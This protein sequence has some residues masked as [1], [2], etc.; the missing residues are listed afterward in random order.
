MRRMRLM[1]RNFGLA[2]TRGAARALAEPFIP[3]GRVDEATVER[4]TAF[5]PPALPAER[6]IPAYHSR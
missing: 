3:R 2:D 5:G 4:C 1:Y 6:I